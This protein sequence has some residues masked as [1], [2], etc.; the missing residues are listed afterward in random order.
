MGILLGWMTVALTYPDAGRVRARLMSRALGGYVGGMTKHAHHST[1]RGLDDRRGAPW[2]RRAALGAVTLAV[3]AAALGWLGPRTATVSAESDGYRLSVTHPAV[4]R[5]GLDAPW[6]VR[7]DSEQ[8]LPPE[9]DIAVTGSYFDIWEAQAFHP[10]PTEA[11]RD[12]EVI[13]LTFVTTPGARTFVVAFDAYIQPAA[14]S[15]AE[16][17]VEVVSDGRTVVSVSHRTR[18]VP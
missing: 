12:G 8:E 7:V 15:G 2:V 4:A 17:T 11:T 13:R 10:E 16:A 1:V 14:Q 18:I 6:R 3:V 9:I 5:A